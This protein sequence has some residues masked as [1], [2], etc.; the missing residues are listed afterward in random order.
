MNNT[1]D[2]HGQTE[3]EA[4]GS[5]LSAILTFEM[6]DEDELEIITGRGSVLTRVTEELLE[7][8]GYHWH[9]RDGNVGS[10]IIRKR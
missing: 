4:I 5:I 6:N 7:E 3:Q 2:L 9:H 10:Y 1:V 8:E